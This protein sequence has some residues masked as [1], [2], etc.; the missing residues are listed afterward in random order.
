MQYKDEGCYIIMHGYIL[1][2]FNKNN[3]FIDKLNSK[4]FYKTSFFN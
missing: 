2:N 4:N 1:H 3:I